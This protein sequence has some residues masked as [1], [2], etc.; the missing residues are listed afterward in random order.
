MG[1]NPV[2]PFGQ[3]PAE[4]STRQDETE[5][6]I[7]AKNTDPEF[8]IR[9]G[10]LLNSLLRIGFGKLFKNGELQIDDGVLNAFLLVP[11]YKHGSR[12]MQTVFKISQLFG[13]TKFN[14]SDLPPETQMD[15][16][17]DGELFYDLLSQKP[18]YFD[19][20][21]AFYYLVNEID[22][23]E[24]IIEQVASG[25]H[26]VYSLVFE[27][28][29]TDDPL[30][31]TKDQFMTYYDKR[32][33]LPE[34]LP[35]D[36]V[37]QNYHNARKIPEKLAAVGF[38]IVPLNAKEPSDTLTK[39]EF[40]KVSWLEHLRWVRHH[41]DNGWQYAPEKNKAAKQHDALVAWDEEDRQN[42]EAFY[43]KSYAQKMGTEPGAMLSDYYRNLDRVITQAIPWILESVGYKMVR[44]ETKQEL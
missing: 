21:K 9:R 43:G 38:A 29:A 33:S 12:S 11:K 23:D 4:V 13:K 40:E 30:A 42:A 35:A 44:S 5:R 7:I 18:K 36:E 24:R 26:A 32:R 39:G 41:I 14:R 20:G 22:L 37:S 31:I 1:P 2:L 10:I 6:F 15:M 25:I 17:V 34:G 16:H 27:L 19:G 8:I 28:G 3:K